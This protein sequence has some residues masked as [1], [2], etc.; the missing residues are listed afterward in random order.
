MRR[1]VAGILL[2]LLSVNLS[3]FVWHTTPVRAEPTT[4]IVDDDGPAD[5]HTIQE[6]VNNANAG[7][8]I[9]VKNGTY[10][11]NVHVSK[12]LSLLGESQ[13]STIVGDGFW[14][15]GNANGSKISGFTI[16][17]FTPEYNGIVLDSLCN[18]TIYRNNI[19]RCEVGISLRGSSNSSISGNN[20]TNSDGNGIW[21]HY[22]A[23]YN[24]ISGN[25][26]ENNGDGIELEYS[27]FNVIFGNN[28]RTNGRGVS[29][30]SMASGEDSSNNMIYHNYFINNTL[31]ARITK[32]TNTWDDGYPSGGNYWSDYAGM[33]GNG[34]GIGDTPYVIN[35]NNIDHY[36]LMKPWTQ[37]PPVITAT[38][39]ICPQ[40]LN[41]KSKGKWITVH[42]ELPEGY[43]AADINVSSIML[44]N[45]VPAEMH[46]NRIK[47]CNGND[48]Q[49]LM[50]KFD[51]EE[52]I[53]YIL[54]SVTS[55][56]R[57]ITATLTLTGKLKD[58]TPFQGSC[59]IKIITHFHHHY[60]HHRFCPHGRLR[61]R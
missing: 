52:V 57:S 25:N 55:G 47:D 4:W 15:S 42:I 18:V 36:P 20:I 50:V 58:G 37:T 26:I 5:F 54:S 6:A 51:R 39:D 16:S 34:D 60:H 32:G 13:E 45:T 44:N 31:Q 23:N 38:V 19:V 1:L 43:N 22:R 61:L 30:Y 14:F 8:T 12:N 11:G 41:L 49:A 2:M 48:I 21:L 59:T 17:A 33:D 7:D 9:L 29:L 46:P 53:K 3:V 10:V 28:I 56:K 27:I 40:T 24:S 35:E